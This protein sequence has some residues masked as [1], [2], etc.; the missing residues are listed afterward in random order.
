MLRR[1]RP[2]AA[3]TVSHVVQH[4]YAGPCAVRGVCCLLV[5]HNVKRE[6]SHKSQC[7]RGCGLIHCECTVSDMSGE[8]PRL[9]SVLI[10]HFFSQGSSSDKSLNL[11]YNPKPS[12]T[13]SAKPEVQLQLIIFEHAYDTHRNLGSGPHY[14]SI[15]PS[16]ECTRH[17]LCR[18]HQDYQ[19][20]A[21]PVLHPAQHSG[22][23]TY[24]IG[25]RRQ[26]RVHEIWRSG[27]A[28]VRSTH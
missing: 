23:G 2:N 5:L 9:C 20:H 17:A 13:S 8:H 19:L 15:P 3:L 16:T 14:S 25:S 4:R 11:H 7:M 10:G 18:R 26:L 12:L 22:R 28:S 21:T 6:L 24:T 1:L 27:Q